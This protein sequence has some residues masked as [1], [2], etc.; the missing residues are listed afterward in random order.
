MSRV[1]RN[2][3]QYANMK[4]LVSKVTWRSVSAH[5]RLSGTTWHG[6]S[7][8]NLSGFLWSSLSVFSSQESTKGHQLSHLKKR[9]FVGEVLG[10]SN[11]S[12]YY[13]DEEL[14][15]NLKMGSPLK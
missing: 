9:P 5:I 11:E 2:G 8:L 12:L 3:R 14:G 15:P 13:P 7:R 10:G 1:S 6:E 4:M